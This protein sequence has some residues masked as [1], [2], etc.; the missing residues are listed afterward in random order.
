MA[1]TLP[2]ELQ[3]I[4]KI[5][6]ASHEQIVSVLNDER[7]Q[8]PAVRDIIESILFTRRFLPT[9]LIVLAVS[10]LLYSATSQIL[11]WTTRRGGSRNTRHVSPSIA[12]SSSSTLQGAESPPL[13]SNASLESTPLLAE[14]QIRAVRNRPTY[15]RIWHNLRAL[16]VHQPKPMAALTAPRNSLPP[17][18]TSL[19]ILALLVLN[20]FYLFW[21]MSLSVRHAFAFADRAGLLFTVNLPVLYILAAK[22][23]QPL[24]WLTGWSYEGLNVF[25][26]RLGEWLTVAAVLH[27]VGMVIGFYQLLAPFGYTLSWY[28]SRRIIILGLLAFIFYMTIY[29]TSIGY[30]RKLFYELFL[31]LHIVLQVGALAFLFFH[32]P[33][34]RPYVGAAVAIWV[35]DRLVSRMVFKTRAFI[36]TFE[37][38]KDGQTV[39]VHCDIPLKSRWISGMQSGWFAGQHVFLTVPELGSLHRLQAHPF[40]IASPAPPR[41]GRDKSW[42]LQLTIR[43]QDGFSRELV[44]YAKLHQ[45]AKILLDGP[46]SSKEVLHAVENADRVCLIAGGSGIAV[47]Y[48][49]A[50]AR[51]AS[52]ITCSEIVHDRKR[53]VNG[54]KCTPTIARTPLFDDGLAHFWIRQDAS[55]ESWITM[56]PSTSLEASSEHSQ[57]AQSALDLITHRF[58]TRSATGMNQRPDVPA[59]LEAWIRGDLKEDRNPKQKV[60]IVVSGPDGLVRDV[61]NTVARLVGEGWNL[62]IHVEKFGW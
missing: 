4:L 12:S 24:Q 5:T 62:E 9:Y 19:A 56:L 3:A 48:P 39:L 52:D 55:H 38:A 61:Q 26:R 21:N 53:Y 41:N 50:W 1:D 17:N 22:N 34:A 6:L 13:K 40:T 45:H 20:L 8:A 35:L 51:L 28:L 60:C 18:E 58:D 57:H 23:N 16:L 11:R 31:A 25:H 27:V 36:A 37:I 7:R 42:P 47:T 32:H 15:V 44:E 49:F 14:A 10:V 59:E 46:Y 43:A 54:K 2:L 30:L 33:N 29:L